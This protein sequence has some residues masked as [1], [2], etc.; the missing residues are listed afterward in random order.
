MGK[1]ISKYENDLDKCW[2]ESSNVLYSECDDKNNQLKTVR[3]TFKDGTTYEYYDVA[4]QDYLLFRESASSG[5]GFFKYIKNHEFTKL[6][7]K[8]D[9]EQI[10]EQL[11]VLLEEAM[12]ITKEKEETDG[13][14]RDSCQ[15]QDCENII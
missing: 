12:E 10:K 4:V 3:I 13:N 1:I 14:K 6:E 5:K 15:E 2:F 8:K 7:E 11:K 9:V